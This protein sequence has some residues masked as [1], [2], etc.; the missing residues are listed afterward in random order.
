MARLRG[1]VAR[2][3][4]RRGGAVGAL[5]R[6]ARRTR[7]A[8]RPAPRSSTQPVRPPRSRSPGCCWPL[9]RCQPPAPTSAARA[10]TSARWPRAWAALAWGTLATLTAAVG[11]GRLGAVVAHLL[12]P[13]VLAGYLRVATRRAGTSGT[14]ATALA[15]AVLGAFCPPLLVLAVLGALV[16]L[17]RG[18]GALRARAAVARRRAPAPA[19]ALGDLRRGTTGGSCSPVP[20]SPY[21]AARRRPPGSWPCCTPTA[22]PRGRVLLSV[23]VLLAGLVAMLR[24][25][26]A[27]GAMTALAVLGLIG[28]ALGLLA[29]HLVL[30]T[31]PAAAAR[32]HRVARHGPGPVGAEPARRGAARPRRALPPAA[33]RLDRPARAHRRG[34][35]RRGAGRARLGRGGRVAGSVRPPCAPRGTWSPRSSPTRRPDRSPVACSSCPATAPR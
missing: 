19:R 7:L 31:D 26:R 11:A 13:L 21:A 4:P 24:R 1:R 25:D 33:V 28:L 34:R 29:P 20:A 12:L 17:V 30:A 14:V 10:V 3:G 5:P 8:G 32:G 9:C 22:R 2:A 18:P 27:S 16:L 23:P 15:V 35:G 6:G